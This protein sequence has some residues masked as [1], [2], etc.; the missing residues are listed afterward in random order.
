MFAMSERSQRYR[1]ELLE[2]MEEFVYPAEPVYERQIAESGDPH[3]RNYSTP[4]RGAD[5]APAGASR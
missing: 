4:D 2:F 1:A 3:Q 5:I